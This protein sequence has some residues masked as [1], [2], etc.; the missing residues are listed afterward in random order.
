MRGSR[1]GE[2]VGS[3]QRTTNVLSCEIW[4][5]D[6]CVA[7]QYRACATRKRRGRT[8]ELSS[9]RHAYS[10]VS[11]QQRRGGAVGMALPRN[12]PASY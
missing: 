6:F 5:L 2:E 4:F 11:N 7:H 12:G 9:N 8:F 3:L 10:L 1:R